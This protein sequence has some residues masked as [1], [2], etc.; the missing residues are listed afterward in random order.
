MTRPRRRIVF[1]DEHIDLKQELD[2]EVDFRRT[3]GRSM[4]KVADT[5]R[6]RRKFSDLAA[7]PAYVQLLLFDHEREEIKHRR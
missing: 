2:N 7:R 1:S 5:P 6:P 4:T 3:F